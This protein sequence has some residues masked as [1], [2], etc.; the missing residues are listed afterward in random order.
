V[1]FAT[2]GLRG[3]VLAVLVVAALALALWALVRE[4]RG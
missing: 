1:A 4:R 3:T 2:T